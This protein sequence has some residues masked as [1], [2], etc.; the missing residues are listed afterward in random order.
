MYVLKLASLTDRSLDFTISRMRFV[1]LG[2]VGHEM[3]NYE[4]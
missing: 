3:Q 4:C 1:A 2:P